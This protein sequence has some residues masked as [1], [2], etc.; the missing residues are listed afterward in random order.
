MFFPSWKEATSRTAPVAT[1]SSARRSLPKVRLSSP[2]EKRSVTKAMEL[3]SGDHA[4]SRSAY[5]SLVRRRTVPLWSSISNRS[6]SP[7]A[8]AANAMRLPSG[9]QVG[10]K[11]SPISGSVNSCSRRPLRA[12]I[13]DSTGLPAE[14]AASAMRRPSALQAPAELMN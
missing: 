5:W 13:T 6:V 14:T 11:I 2:V 4:G 8:I 7:P 12:S 9:D 10:L 1:S 3:P